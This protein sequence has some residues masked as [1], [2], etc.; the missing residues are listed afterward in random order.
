MKEAI[1]E[2]LDKFIS[3]TVGCSGYWFPLAELTV[4]IPVL[5]YNIDKFFDEQSEL[6][7]AVM[8]EC[9]IETVTEVDYESG[10][11]SVF[12]G[13]NI[14]ALLDEQYEYEVFDLRFWRPRRREI[15]YT[16]PC[17]TEAFYFDESKTWLMYVSHEGTVAFAGAELAAAAQR[18]IPD[19]YLF[20]GWDSKGKKATAPPDSSSF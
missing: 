10:P 6:L 7:A 2:N 8:R 17:H 16:F 19:R 9:G 12:E 14:F 18:I 20:Y 1:Y 15:R 3:D 13:Q 5:A 11:E 4:D